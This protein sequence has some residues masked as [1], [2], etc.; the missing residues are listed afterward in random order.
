MNSRIVQFKDLGRIGYQAA[1][2]LQHELFRHIEQIKIQNRDAPFNDQIPTPNYL[3]FC[4]HPP[5]YTLGKNGSLDNLLISEQSMAQKGITFHKTN[6]GGDI[7]YHGPGQLVGYPILDL[8]NFTPDI[9][10][11]MRL[12]EET[13]IQALK[14]YGIEADR[15][16]KHTGVWLDANDPTHS[17]KICAQGVKTSRWITMHG[18]AFNLNPDLWYFDQIIPCGIKDRGVT[19][20]ARE[21]GYTPDAEEVKQ[22][23]KTAFQQVFEAEITD[24]T[25][26]LL[27]DYS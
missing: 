6:R 10:L 2:D 23:L 19:S 20:M 3:L 22:T 27:L 24:P 25:E 26:Q 5:V 17:R 12:L 7:T 9:R 18:W 14:T 21:L 1:W 13:I 15:L 11:Y 4:E 8:D 16:E